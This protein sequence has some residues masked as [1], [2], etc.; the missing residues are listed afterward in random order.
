MLLVKY[1][2]SITI[3]GEQ[4]LFS[5]INKDK[6]IYQ[7]GAGKLLITHLDGNVIIIYYQ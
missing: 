7:I 5:D 1:D 6:I 2:Q 3:F 4:K